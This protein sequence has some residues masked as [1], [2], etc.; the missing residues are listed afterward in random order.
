MTEQKIIIFSN[1]LSLKTY[2]IQ[3]E[4]VRTKGKIPSALKEKII[5]EVFL[6][7]YFF[8]SEL[9][10]KTFKNINFYNFIFPKLINNKSRNFHFN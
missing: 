4:K 8:K 3:N 9:N 5:N 6:N 1:N 7:I 10:F 2:W